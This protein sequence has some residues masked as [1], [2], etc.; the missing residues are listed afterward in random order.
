MIR[1]DPRA[2]DKPAYHV[3]YENIWQ[4]TPRDTHLFKFL[5]VSC[6]KIK[7]SI[8]QLMFFQSVMSEMLYFVFCLHVWEK[9]E[10]I[11]IG[12]SS[13]MFVLLRRHRKSL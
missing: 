2:L 6:T 12:F 7:I 4:D 9:V 8:T 5:R 1:Y 11:R 3:K 13:N 10:E